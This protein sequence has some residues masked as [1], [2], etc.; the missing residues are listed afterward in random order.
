MLTIQ[1][2]QQAL[3]AHRVVSLP[4]GNYHGPL[5]LERLAAIVAAIRD[6]EGVTVGGGRVRRVLELSSETWEKLDQLAR[7][8]ASGANHPVSASQVAAAIIEQF[9]ETTTEA[10]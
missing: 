2:I 9:V 1:E 3:H 5:G 6:D 10:R 8:A 4:G 7:S